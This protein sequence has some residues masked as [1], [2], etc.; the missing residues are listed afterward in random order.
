MA[1]LFKFNLNDI[2][3]KSFFKKEIK[4][5]IIGGRNQ[6]APSYKSLVYK[7]KKGILLDPAPSNALSTIK[8][9]GRDH[10]MRDTGDLSQHGFGSWA[11]P[12]TMRVYASQKRHSGK[13]TY[14]TKSGKKRIRKSKKPPTYYQLFSWHNA[15]GYSGIFQQLP[16][17]SQFPKRMEKEILKQLKKALGGNIKHIKMAFN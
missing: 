3:L 6:G 2:N 12:H 4:R 16:K 9:K 13:S 17:G 15:K 5:N 8:R 10:W 11:K 7:L 14:I 1:V